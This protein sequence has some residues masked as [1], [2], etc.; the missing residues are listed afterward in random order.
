RTRREPDPPHEKLARRVVPDIFF[1]PH[2]YLYRRAGASST[3]VRAKQISGQGSRDKLFTAREDI[4]PLQN[5]NFCEIVKAEVR[6]RI[7]TCPSKQIGIVRRVGGS[8]AQ[9]KP[10]LV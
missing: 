6:R 9:Y 7:E 10:E 2:P 8:L 1:R 3:C 5:R 4:L